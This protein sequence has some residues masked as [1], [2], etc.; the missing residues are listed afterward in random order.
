MNLA[1]L[2][3]TWWICKNWLWQFHFYNQTGPSTDDYICGA[4]YRKAMYLEVLGSR[5][6]GQALDKSQHSEEENMSELPIFMAYG[7]MIGCNHQHANKLKRQGKLAVSLI[8]RTRGQ[9]SRQTQP[10]QTD[11]GRSE[12]ETESQ[13]G[14]P[15]SVCEVC[16]ESWLTL[17][18]C[19]CRTGSKERRMKE[20]NGMLS[21]GPMTKLV[22][23]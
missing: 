19:M 2:Q 7:L 21:F 5:R 22:I 6:S 11:R 15:I 1:R 9:C 23:C 3:D 12:K 20:L 13:E 14:R 18:T 16:P 17:E 8:W 4:T 10:L